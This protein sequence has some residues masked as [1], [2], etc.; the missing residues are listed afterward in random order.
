LLQALL[1]LP[2]PV[3]RHHQILLGPDGRR[4]A[5]RDHAETLRALRDKGDSPA[6]LRAELGFD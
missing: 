3:Y 1:G 4:Y 5:K 6:A 2:A